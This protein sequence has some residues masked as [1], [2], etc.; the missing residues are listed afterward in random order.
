MRRDKTAGRLCRLYIFNVD[1]CRATALFNPAGSSP[2]RA[3]TN[4]KHISI[5][6]GGNTT[7]RP[8]RPQG[9]PPA[10]HRDGSHRTGHRDGSHRTRAV[11]Q[12]PRGSIY[13]ACRATVITLH[14]LTLSAGDR[15]I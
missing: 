10:G 8:A 9:T 5:I 15:N 6:V 13:D 14:C 7:S 11:N 4:T 3:P 12:P 2:V 1:A